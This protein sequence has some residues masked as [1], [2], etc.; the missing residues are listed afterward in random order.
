MPD[1]PVNATVLLLAEDEAVLQTVLEA[2]LSSEGFSVVPASSG[3]K[4]MAELDRDDAR[5]QGVIADVRLGKGPSGWDVGRRA[6]EVFP[7][8]PVIYMTGDSAH[9]WS[10]HGVPE[11]IVLQKPFVPAQLITAI[12][13]L[14]NEAGTASAASDARAKSAPTSEG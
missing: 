9:E 10:A 7:A 13:T 8:V 11:S 1:T 6:R 12:A 4:A 5:F 2:A 14:L 3:V